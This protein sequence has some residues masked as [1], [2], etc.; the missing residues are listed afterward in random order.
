MVLLAFTM[1]CC[2]I[3]AVQLTVPKT[4]SSSLL[5]ILAEKFGG[6]LGGSNA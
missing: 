4:A 2:K 3:V 1:A 5:S 6:E